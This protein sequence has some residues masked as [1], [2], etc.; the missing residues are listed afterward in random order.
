MT[1]GI[2]TPRRVLLAPQKPWRL[3]LPPRMLI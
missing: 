3:L 1:E 2:G